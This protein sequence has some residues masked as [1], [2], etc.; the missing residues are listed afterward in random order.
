MIAV[1]KAI[2]YTKRKSRNLNKKVRLR[3]SEIERASADY[4]ETKKPVKRG[5]WSN[6][7]VAPEW[8]P[9]K[10]AI[11][12]RLKPDDHDV[13][14]RIDEYSNLMIDPTGVF[15]SKTDSY[16]RENEELESSLKKE[17]KRYKELYELCLKEQYLDASYRLDVE[18]IL[19][20]ANNVRKETSKDKVTLQDYQALCYRLQKENE[21]FKKMEALSGAVSEVKYDLFFPD[22]SDLS[23]DLSDTELRDAYM[24]GL[25]TM[26]Q[27]ALNTIEKRKP[28]DVVFIF[29][30]FNINDL[31]YFIDQ[32]VPFR[33]KEKNVVI[34]C[35]DPLQ[36]S[37]RTNYSSS[38]NHLR[39]LKP[40]VVLVVDD[41]G[42]PAITTLPRKVVKMSGDIEGR[43]K[44][45][46]RKNIDYQVVVEG[47]ENVSIKRSSNE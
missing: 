35:C 34:A 21:N 1:M 26:Y 25:N 4:T 20:D 28:N 27:D 23:S 40:R 29:H 42:R 47:Y 5:C 31:K 19:A 41:P 18:E 12:G 9:I 22:L 46:F 3:T 2:A 32:E 39:F 45:I 15:K 44:I 13:W 7:G 8:T 10:L 33:F 14:L 43:L 16:I 30:I 37:R 17:Q 38:A 11:E 6:K 24:N 36:T